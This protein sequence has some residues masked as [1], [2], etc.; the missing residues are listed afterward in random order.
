MRPTS[1]CASDS[2]SPVRW[3]AAP[4][5]RPPKT[6]H[7]AADAKPE[8]TTSGGATAKSMAIRKKMIAVRTSGIAAVAQKPTAKTISPLARI[9]WAGT[10]AGTGISSSAADAAR[11]R[12]ARVG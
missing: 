10:S 2:P 7:N 6:S 5:N 1:I 4:M 8:N 11:T 9:S 3:T 12:T